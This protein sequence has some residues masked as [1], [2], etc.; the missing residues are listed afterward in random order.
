MNWSDIVALIVKYGVEQAFKIWEIA[1]SGEPDAAAWEKL[2]ALSL[3]SYDDYIA[4]A[5]ERAAQAV[6]MPGAQP[7]A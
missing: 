7:P 6:T 1:Q 4:A 5:R 2:K 3:V